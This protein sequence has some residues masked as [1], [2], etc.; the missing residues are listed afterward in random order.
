V[1]SQEEVA[2]VRALHAEGFNHVWQ[3]ELI[4]RDSRHLLRGLLHSD[5]CRVD[6]WVNRTSYPRYEFTN[7]STDIQAIFGRACDALGIE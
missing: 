4:D 1:Y 5:G 6:N 7:V 3:Q 2:L